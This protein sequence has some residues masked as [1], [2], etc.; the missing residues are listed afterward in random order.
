MRVVAR[1]SPPT[2]TE[3]DRVLEGLSGKM[4]RG[5]VTPSEKVEYEELLAQRTRMFVRMPVLPPSVHRGLAMPHT[6]PAE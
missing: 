5:E 2:E 6:E 3:I 1:R 4:L